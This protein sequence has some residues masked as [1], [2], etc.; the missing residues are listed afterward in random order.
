MDKRITYMQAAVQLSRR[1]MDRGNGGP[2]GAVVVK[3]G[4]I[5]GR[6][7]NRVLSDHDPT[8]HAEMVAIRD[9]C[10]HLQDFQ[11][12]GCEIYASCEPCPMCLGAIYWAGVDKIY[13]ANTREDA[14][15]IGFA[16]A[17]I[18]EEIMRPVT[19]RRI[20]TLQMDVPEAIAVFHEWTDK[21]DKTRY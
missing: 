15:E 6:G 20:P 19:N 10:R 3:A 18:Y 8:A 21:E 14:K 5:I 17:F 9:A 12:A 7:Y 4:K 2:F 16:D 13:Y 1:G 11:L